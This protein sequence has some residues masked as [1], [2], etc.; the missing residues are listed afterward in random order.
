MTD[1]QNAP[2]TL[3]QVLAEKTW[4]E[5][6]AADASMSAHDSSTRGLL[7]RCHQWRAVAA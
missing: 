4:A 2:G 6:T 3:G 1:A 5:L 7:Q